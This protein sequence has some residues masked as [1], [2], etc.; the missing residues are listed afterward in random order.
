METLGRCKNDIFLL[1][2]LLLVFGFLF[3][4]F[5]SSV[6]THQFLLEKC[7]QRGS[8]R[9]GKACRLFPTHVLHMREE[10]GVKRNKGHLKLSLL[11]SAATSWQ[12]CKCR[13]QK[14]IE[15]CSNLSV[16]LRHSSVMLLVSSPQPTAAP[17][18]VSAH[19]RFI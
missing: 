17:Q 3:V 5:L 18:A 19:L 10:L 15:N 9:R 16:S 8:A 12:V 13:Q 2:L 4:C 11:L 6:F 1:L 14:L 7:S